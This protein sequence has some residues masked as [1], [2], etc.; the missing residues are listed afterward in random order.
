LTRKPT[1]AKFFVGAGTTICSDCVERLHELINKEPDPEVP[2]TQAEAIARYSDEELLDSLTNY[3]ATVTAAE[4][5]GSEPS[6][7]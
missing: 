5:A 7:I 1:N 3:A 2:R 4:D 6:S